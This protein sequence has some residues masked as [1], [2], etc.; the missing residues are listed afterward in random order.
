MPLRCLLQ[1]SSTHWEK[2]CSIQYQIQS[3]FFSSEPRKSEATDYFLLLYHLTHAPLYFFAGTRTRAGHPTS[4]LSSPSCSSSVFFRIRSR[5]GVSPFSTLRQLGRK[6]TI[7]WQNIYL[8]RI[9][10]FRGNSNTSNGVP[11]CRIPQKMVRS[12]HKPFLCCA[13]K[14]TI[15]HPEKELA[16]EREIFRHFPSSAPDHSGVPLRVQGFC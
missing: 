14:L 8:A 6:G 5:C 9:L 10:V 16:R 1:L 15:K 4:S 2:N 3:T 7:C 13:Y 11:V 12:R